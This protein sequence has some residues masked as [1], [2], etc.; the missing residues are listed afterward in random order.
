MQ[1]KASKK[2]VSAM[3]PTCLRQSKHGSSTP[4]VTLAPGSGPGVEPQIMKYIVMNPKFWIAIIVMWN[5][6]LG[7]SAGAD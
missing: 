7:L 2:Q 6:I 3:K 1:R 4:P 5:T